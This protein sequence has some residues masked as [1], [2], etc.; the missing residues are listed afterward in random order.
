M[1]TANFDGTI[2]SAPLIVK[3]NDVIYPS[4][5]LET[6]RALYDMPNYNTK[7]TPEVGI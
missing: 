6:L 2:R 4:L 5:A 7:V 1:G 3:A